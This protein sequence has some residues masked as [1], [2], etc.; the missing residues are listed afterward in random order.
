MSNWF[1][2]GIIPVCVLFAGAVAISFSSTLCA[3]L[4]YTSSGSVLKD[5]DNPLNSKNKSIVHCWFLSATSC[6]CYKEEAKIN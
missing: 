1:N 3:L 2:Y 5:F 4:Y 6:A